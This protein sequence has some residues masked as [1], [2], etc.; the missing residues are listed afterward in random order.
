KLL[1]QVQGRPADP[2]P[3]RRGRVCGVSP[4]R[5]QELKTGTDSSLIAEINKPKTR[6]INGTLLNKKPDITGAQIS[7]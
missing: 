2:P 6:V 3:P 7:P 5:T 4:V 1:S